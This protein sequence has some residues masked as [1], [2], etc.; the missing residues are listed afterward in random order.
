MVGVKSVVLFGHELLVIVVIV[1]TNSNACSGPKQ[2]RRVDTEA[3][4]EISVDFSEDRGKKPIRH[5]NTW[6]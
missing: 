5:L 3:E 2:S 6:L 1:K 4:V